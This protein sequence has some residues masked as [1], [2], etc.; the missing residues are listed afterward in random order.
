MS[1]T[2]NPQIDPQIVLEGHLPAKDLTPDPGSGINGTTVHCP[3]Q[4]K[5]STVDYTKL[6]DITVLTAWSSSSAA[7]RVVVGRHRVLLRQYYGIRRPPRVE[8]FSREMC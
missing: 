5:A 8:T 2:N 6:I 4:T 3:A 7:C 1:L